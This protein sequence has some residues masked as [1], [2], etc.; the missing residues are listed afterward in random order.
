MAAG[1]LDLHLYGTIGRL[2][3]TVFV[4]GCVATVLAVRRRGLLL[5][6]LSTPLVPILAI[7]IV[8][9]AF[10]RHNPDTTVLLLSAAQPV[11]SHFPAIAGITALVA[12]LGALRIFRPRR[13]TKDTEGRES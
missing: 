3:S 5:V 10:T 7:L 1:W 4:L 13:S 2:T 12:A 8:V 11:V 9:L 6:M